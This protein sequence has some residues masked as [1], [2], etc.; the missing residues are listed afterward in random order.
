MAN[1][2]EEYG[3]EEEYEQD[4]STG[5]EICPET[6]LPYI[7]EDEAETKVY[8]AASKIPLFVLAP[9]LVTAGIAALIYIAKKD[10]YEARMTRTVASVDGAGW[11]FLAGG[12]FAV[13]VELAN[14]LPMIWKGAVMP[15]NAGNLRANMTIYRV[16]QSKP[17][18]YVVMENDGYI[19]KYNR[20]NRS[21]YHFVENG[22]LVLVTFLLAGAIF[23]EAVFVLVLLYAI[24]RI[25]YQI[26]YT[27][28]GYGIGCCK[29]GIP[30]A[31]HTVIIAHTL[32]MLVWIA[33]VRMIMLQN[34]EAAPGTPALAN[35]AA[36]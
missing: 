5:P 28:G 16:Q 11:L 22:M 20:A 34:S 33:G 3:L 30:F 21:M 31:F 24:C 12:V 17:L 1:S 8:S 14:T 36:V 26:A 35:A 23:G 19:G 13:L 32:E 10:L 6:G 15:G 27:N 9:R 29:H 7:D 18:P 2:E 4:E 25:W